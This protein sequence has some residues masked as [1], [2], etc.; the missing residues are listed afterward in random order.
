ML[1]E[2]GE[3]QGAAR[4]GKASS[5]GGGSRGG[6]GRSSGAHGGSARREES[7][8][9]HPAR[10]LDREDARHYSGFLG[11]L[12]PS[13][14]LSM[15]VPDLL[16]SLLELGGAA[17][18]P[19]AV[20]RPSPAPSGSARGQQQ[21]HHPQPQPGRSGRG[22]QWDGGDSAHSAEAAMPAPR[23]GARSERH[24]APRGSAQP[25]AEAARGGGDEQQW[26]EG[27]EQWDTPTL[28]GGGRRDGDGGALP[29]HEVWM[30]H[31]GDWAQMHG[32]RHSTPQV[33]SHLWV[34]TPSFSIAGAAAGT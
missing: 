25:A 31:E 11:Q 33:R 20:G 22:E 21:Q 6:R 14:E 19:A 2:Q 7:G 8:S 16:A 3:A 28:G 13:E 23:R 1:P 4:G 24:P 18:N 26:E 27:M 12:S 34:A 5:S 9:V 15:D 10:L 29:L 30:Q 32:T 17:P